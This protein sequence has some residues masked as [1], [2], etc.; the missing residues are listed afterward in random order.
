MNNS[1]YEP[2][3]NG[4]RRQV[5]PRGLKL[6]IWF[7]V[8]LYL[9]FA[10]MKSENIDVL[11]WIPL[12]KALATNFFS[13]HITW[14]ADHGHNVEY[15]GCWLLSC[16][17]SEFLFNGFSD[18]GLESS[19]C[20][21]TSLPCWSWSRLGLGTGNLGL[22]LGLVLWRSRSRSKQSAETTETSKILIKK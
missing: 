13:V 2:I 17:I 18:G 21:E 11:T 8:V 15:I 14:G 5:M 6:W 16:K 12:N 3:R 22:G 10:H 20:L 9:F 19:S 7:Q 4:V 1:W